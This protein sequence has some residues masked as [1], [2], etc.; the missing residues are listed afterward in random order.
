MGTTLL[1]FPALLDHVYWQGWSAH[2]VWL[3]LLWAWMVALLLLPM[4]SVPAQLLSQSLLSWPD[5]KESEPH[6]LS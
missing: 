6:D 4:L 5:G 1:F 2:M 3:A